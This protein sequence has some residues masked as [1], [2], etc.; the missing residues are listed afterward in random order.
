MSPTK[1]LVSL[2]TPVPSALDVYISSFPSLL[3]TNTSLVP[4][5][6]GVTVEVCESVGLLVDVPV[7]VAVGV[8]VK[9]GV[10]VGVC[11]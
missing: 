1:F 6:V 9:V 5:G 7:C 4:S 2:V 8:H 10:E 3:E 11:V